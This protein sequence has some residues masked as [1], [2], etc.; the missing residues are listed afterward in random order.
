MIARAAQKYG[1]IVVDKGGAVAFK[2][3]DPY[4]FTQQNGID[5]YGPYAF[6]GQSPSKLLGV[7]PWQQLQVVQP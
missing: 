1:M 4:L 7:F 6:G 2:A 3:E 5:P